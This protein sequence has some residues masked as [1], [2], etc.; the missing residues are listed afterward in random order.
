MDKEGKP[1]R[2]TNYG[3][4]VRA[5]APGSD[6][7]SIFFD[8]FDGAGPPEQ[9]YDPDRFDGWARWSGTSFAAPAVVATLARAV[10]KGTPPHDAVARLI[11]D[12]Q[13]DRKPMLGTIVDP[14]K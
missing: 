12:K 7:V 11:D 3:P 8:G 2:F 13:L 4:W 5:C 9:N 10:G 1:A 14:E 6:V